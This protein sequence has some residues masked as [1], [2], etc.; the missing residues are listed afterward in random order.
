VDRCRD[1]QYGRDPV[2]RQA[3]ITLPAIGQYFFKKSTERILQKNRYI[4]LY[5]LIDYPGDLSL[6]KADQTD[7]ICYKN[8]EGKKG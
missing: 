7:K 3:V 6:L 8:Y 2:A 1:Q 5:F 4:Q